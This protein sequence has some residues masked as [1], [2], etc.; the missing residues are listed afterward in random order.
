MKKD[1]GRVTQTSQ[2]GGHRPPNCE[3]YDQRAIEAFISVHAPDYDGGV[4]TTE[5]K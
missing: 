4:L 5:A 1:K 2:A 3:V